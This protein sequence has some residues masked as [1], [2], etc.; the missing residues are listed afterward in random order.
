MNGLIGLLCFIWGFNWVI[1]KMSN[2]F[3]P[4]VLFAGYRYGVGAAVLLAVCLI[5][6]VP[7]PARKDWKW[8]ILCGILQTAYFNIAIQLA[9][10]HI[11]A[12]LTSVLTYSMP[13]WLTVMA[14]FLIPGERLTIRKTAGVAAGMA[15]MCLAM[16]IT[17]GGG[18]SAMLLALSSGLSW[19]VSNV[20][21]KR[22]LAHCNNLQFTTWQMV[23]GAAAMLLYSLC[24]EHGQTHWG[25]MPVVYVLFTG[26]VGSAFAFVLWFHILSNTEASKASIS[27]LLVP[28]VGVLSGVLVLHESLSMPTIGG[29]LFVLA[30]IWLVNSTSKKKPVR[31]TLPRSASRLS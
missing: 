22:K 18:L 20:I 16:D 15:G 28:V 1:M 31:G 11:S 17:L 4:P 29:I 12:G 25:T 19:A 10:Q 5:K 8:Y 30:G 3:F 14:H 6:R 23:A 2:D 21:I 24:F 7:L 9:L 26:I 27:L 13:L